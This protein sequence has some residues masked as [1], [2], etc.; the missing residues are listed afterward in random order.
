[1]DSK[2]KSHALPPV[3]ARDYT[4]R[5]FRP[6]F[7]MARLPALRETHINL[8]TSAA[9]KALIDRAAEAMGQNRSE[10]MLGASLQRARETLADQTRFVLDAP[11]WEAFHAALDAPLAAEAQAALQRLLRRK[12]PWPE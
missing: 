12:P 4:V 5:T 10:F 2:E 11:Q 9:D 6:E 1:M 7:V 8:R 3:R